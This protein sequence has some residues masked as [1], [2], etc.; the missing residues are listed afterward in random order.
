MMHQLL[1]LLASNQEDLTKDDV[2]HQ[3]NISPTRLE[4]MLMVLEQKGKVRVALNDKIELC[5]QHASCP[6]TGKACPGPE[7]CILI[8]KM[9]LGIEVIAEK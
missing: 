5:K 8:M 4:N 3:L 9:P 1:D 6:S 7:N 2:C